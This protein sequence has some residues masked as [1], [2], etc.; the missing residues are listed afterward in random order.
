[1]KNRRSFLKLSACVPSWCLAPWIW[2]DGNLY[3]DENSHFT[4]GGLLSQ[5]KGRQATVALGREYLTQNPGEASIDK[6]AGILFDRSL[7]NSVFK[8]TSCSRK[9]AAHL[10]ERVQ[11]DFDTENVVELSGLL[12]SRTEA[13][14]CG[15]VSLEN[16]AST[17]N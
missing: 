1:M 5:L 11:M 8:D 4:W 16:T 13:R 2:Q 15:L 14:L 6:L 10:L 3:A 12:L 7:S 17:T 9:A